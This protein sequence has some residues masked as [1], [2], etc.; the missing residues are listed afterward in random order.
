M[1]DV[2]T[3]MAHFVHPKE[4]EMP[5]LPFD[6]GAPK[7]PWVSRWSFKKNGQLV[8]VAVRIRFADGRVELTDARDFIERL[9]G[10][11]PETSFQILFDQMQAEP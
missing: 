1:T 7:T 4:A 11:D 6:G 9:A 5:M 8:R 2:R 3:L 10:F